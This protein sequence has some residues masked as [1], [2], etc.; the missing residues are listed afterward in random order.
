MRAGLHALADR[1]DTGLSAR[2]LPYT[3][4][5]SFKASNVSVGQPFPDAI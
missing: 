2:R 1:K 3:R 5:L 4:S